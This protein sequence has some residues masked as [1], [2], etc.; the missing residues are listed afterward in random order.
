MPVVLSF[1]EHHKIFP[2]FY[3]QPCRFYRASPLYAMP[4]PLSFCWT[5]TSLLMLISKAPPTGGTIVK[6]MMLHCP[7]CVMVWHALE[8]HL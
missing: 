8:I 1:I 5:V 2:S 6:A 4:S 7:Y 3:N